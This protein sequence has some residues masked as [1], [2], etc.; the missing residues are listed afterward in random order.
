MSTYFDKLAQ[1]KQ[2][3]TPHGGRESTATPHGTP[4]R[5]SS[6]PSPYA[7]RHTHTGTGLRTGGGD[8]TVYESP[9]RRRRPQSA[10]GRGEDPLP[11]YPPKVAVTDPEVEMVDCGTQV[12]P[13]EATRFYFQSSERS[14]E[15]AAPTAFVRAHFDVVVERDEDDTWTTMEAFERVAY[16][17]MVCPPGHRPQGVRQTAETTSHSPDPVGG[18]RWTSLDNAPPGTSAFHF[19]IKRHPPK[20]VIHPELREWLA[21]VS[22]MRPRAWDDRALLS[23]LQAGGVG[24]ECR[25]C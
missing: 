1:A 3:G 15:G 5:P 25:A 23:K 17:E 9:W 13:A 14:R 12:A 21:R 20:M 16:D 8:D 6:S 4:L 7:P 22:S 24:I 10:R 19:D 11:L 18:V 2:S